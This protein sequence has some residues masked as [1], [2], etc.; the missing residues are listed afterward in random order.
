MSSEPVFPQPRRP[1]GARPT[2]RRL[3]PVLFLVSAFAMTL[4][5]ARSY[6][7]QSDEGYTLNAAWQTWTGMRMYDDFRL[8]VGPGTGGLVY[9]LWRIV[10]SPS[11]LAARL[12]SLAL[13]FSSTTAFYL[14]LRRLGIHGLGLAAAVA[15]WLVLSSLCVLLNHNA[16]STF[17]AVWF[18]LALVRLLH[19]SPNGAIARPKTG[20][21]ALVG[22]AAGV[23]FAFL[24]PKGLLLAFCATIQLFNIGRKER[25]YRPTLCLGAGFLATIAPLFIIKNPLVL[26]RQWL[27]IPLTG[28][29]LGHTSAS[30]GYLLAAVA[31]LAGMVWMVARSPHEVLKTLVMVQAALFLST[32]HNMEMVHL[33]INLF[34]AVIFVFFVIQRRTGA[35]QRQGGMSSGL[36]L[37]TF[38]GTLAVWMFTTTAGRSYA[39][40]SV[41]RADVLGERA[42]PAIRPRI[43]EAHAIYA[44]PFLPG[45]YYLLQK[46]NPYFV[47]ETV[48]CNHDCQRQLVAQLE[49]VRPE[50]AFLAYDMVSHLRYPETGPVD[51]YLREHYTACPSDGWIPMRAITPEWCP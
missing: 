4:M 27:I 3:E 16:F 14:L 6:L 49:R 19:E 22:V 38:A 28:N 1:A 20:A 48:V 7:V 32:V 10:G 46:K 9:W 34:P 33:V 31:L 5:L 51:V 15:C 2:L 42:K 17:A 13:S 40:A 21:S 24:P 12:L 11:Y 44:G 41:F 45:V 35:R 50:I 29:Y 8:F 18:L 43:A 26:I 25:D 36:A 37:A 47:S 23:I 39:A 30:F